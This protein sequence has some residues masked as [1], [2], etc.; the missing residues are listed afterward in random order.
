[1]LAARAE[2]TLREA[3]DECARLGVD[4]LTVVTDVRDDIAVEALAA[5][6]KSASDAS[7]S[8]STTPR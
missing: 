3:G 6:A 8:G 4:V 2:S 7:T 5:R 1:V